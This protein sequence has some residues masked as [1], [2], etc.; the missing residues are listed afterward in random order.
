MNFT[1]TPLTLILI[2]ANVIFSLVGFSNAD[3]MTKSIGWPY[4]T[5]RENQYYRFITSGFLHADWMHLFF[6]MFTLYFFGSNIEQIFTISGLGGNVAYLALYFLGLIASDLPSYFKHRDDYNYKS[7]GASGA[8]SAIV[9]A[10]IVFSPWSSLYLY[11][12]LKV[13]ATLFAVL[14]IV[15]CV[16]MGKRNADNVNHDAHLWGALFGLTFTIALIALM[17]PALFDYIIE[18]FKKPSLFGRP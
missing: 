10:S 3:V 4:Y 6:N 11:G 2:G 1:E 17:Q 18:E 9:F 8:V 13:S 7:L 16:Y 12:A 14:Y 15:Y 5:K